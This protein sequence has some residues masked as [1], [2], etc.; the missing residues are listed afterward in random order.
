MLQETLDFIGDLT[1]WLTAWTAYITSFIV[2]IDE[3]FTY[4]KAKFEPLRRMAMLLLSVLQPF[5]NLLILLVYRSH[6]AVSPAIKVSRFVPPC[7]L[8]TD[9][10]QAILLNPFPCAVSSAIHAPGGPAGTRRH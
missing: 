3:A 1:N 8:P 6:A 4:I 5:F 9:C 2:P 10:S 7:C